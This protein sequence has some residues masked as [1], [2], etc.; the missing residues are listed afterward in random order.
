MLQAYCRARQAGLHNLSGSKQIS[1]KWCNACTALILLL[2][3]RTQE[4]YAQWPCLLWRGE[5]AAA[6]AP[7]AAVI[8]A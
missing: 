1:M 7:F 2:F 3:V 4:H 8:H 5:L 6:A